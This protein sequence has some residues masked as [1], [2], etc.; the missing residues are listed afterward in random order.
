[1][2]LFFVFSIVTALFLSGCTGKAPANTRT[3]TDKHNAEAVLDQ[4]YEAVGKADFDGFIAQFSKNAVFYGTDATEIWAFEE[5]APSIK[6]SFST[7]VGWD[8][9]LIDRRLTLSQSGDVVWFSE[10]AHFNNT[11]YLL[12]P[13]GVMEKQDGAWKIIQIVMGI[14]IPNLL[15]PPVLQGMQAT[16]LGKDVETGKINAVL[17]NVH[18]HAANADGVAYFALYDEDAIF[19]GTDVSERWTKAQFQIYAEPSFSQGKGWRY[20]PRER[21]VVLSPMSNMAWFDE[22]LDSESYGTSRGTGVL[23]RTKDGWKISQYHLTFPIPNDLADAM[24]T[25]IKAYEKGAQ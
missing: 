12:R 17:D 20:T 3:A 4:Y 2:R 13:T 19:I 8:F 22:I 23:V 9:D 10:L 7:G 1:M 14:P 6:E 5:F 18:K 11:D 24:T 15:Y 25:Q 16:T 21:H